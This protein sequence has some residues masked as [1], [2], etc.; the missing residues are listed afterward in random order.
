M[1]EFE[2]ERT[3]DD[4]YECARQ[5][6]FDN[7][8][9]IEESSFAQSV[10]AIESE[11]GLRS[12]VDLLRE[13]L[14]RLLNEYEPQIDG[15]D[16]PENVRALIRQEFQRIGDQVYHAEDGYFDLQNRL[17]RCDF[18]LACFSRIPVGVEDIEPSGILSVTFKPTK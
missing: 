5:S 14:V 3:L 17:T 16:Y 4:L 1:S 12:R 6:A 11:Q 9:P 13:T 7:Q 10:A 15:L 2:L 18:R 8:R